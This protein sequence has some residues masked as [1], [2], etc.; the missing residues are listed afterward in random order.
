MPHDRDIRNT[1]GN[2]QFGSSLK[3]LEDGDLARGYF[4]AAPKGNY[5]ASLMDRDEDMWGD[6]GGTLHPGQL[7]AD[8]YREKHGTDD[9]YGFVRRP[10]HRT[11]IERS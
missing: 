7:E 11:D 9:E 6:Y 2:T 4:N 3:D 1:V 5:E 10:R 8:G